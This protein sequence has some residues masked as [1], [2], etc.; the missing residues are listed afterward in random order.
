MF[1]EA[2]KTFIKKYGSAPL[3]TGEL[4]SRQPTAHQQQSTCHYSD[5]VARDSLSNGSA[6]MEG[7]D[8]AVTSATSA[9]R[10]HLMCYISAN[11][12]P[13][14]IDQLAFARLRIST[15]LNIRYFGTSANTKMSR[16]VRKL[17]AWLHFS[18][19][20]HI[21]IIYKKSTTIQRRVTK[22]FSFD[23]LMW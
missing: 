19:I 3:C 10:V 7:R 15:H 22:I 16:K 14:G 20:V 13:F 12:Y 11:R 8:N 5:V 18:N 1:P 9:R 23:D 17:S 4:E 2:T 6:I 21:K